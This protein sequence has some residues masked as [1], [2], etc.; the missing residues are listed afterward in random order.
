MQEFLLNGIASIATFPL[1][2]AYIPQVIQTYRTKNVEGISLP[3]WILI[4]VALFLLLVNSIVV[5]AVFGTW[6]YMLMETF[7]FGLA[8]TMLV[9]TLKYRRKKAVA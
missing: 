3:F 5:F 2:A 6:G 4:T 1:V 9:M 7:N 8:A